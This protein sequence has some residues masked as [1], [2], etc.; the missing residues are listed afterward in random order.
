MLVKLEQ[1]NPSIFPYS[2]GQ[3]KQANPATSFPQSPSNDLLA[4][5]E[6]YPVAATEP[7]SCD[8]ATHCLF[9]WVELANEEW[10]QTWTKARLSEEK[11]AANV[12]TKRNIL[13][14]Y[15]D[16]T[17][18]QDSPLDQDTKVAWAAYREE[19]RMIPDQQGFPWDIQWPVKPDEN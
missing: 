12:R 17:Q 16:W 19:L 5:Y 1:G 2:V 14:S 9:T 8:F 11:A 7:P 3:L 4:F 18:L 10:T 13:L 6:V 15:S